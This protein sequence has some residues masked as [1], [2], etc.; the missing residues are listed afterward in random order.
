MLWIAQNIF[1]VASAMLRTIDYIEAYSLTRLRIAA[2]AWMALVAFGLAA[3]CW[4]LLRDRSAAWLIN[5]NLAAAGL[6]LT[7]ASFIDLGAIAAQ[8]NVR[9]AREVGGQGAA[10]DLCYLSELEAS[11]LLPLIALEQRPGLQPAFR[12]RVQ[13]VRSRV[14]DALEDSQPQG[15]TL[16]GQRQLEQVRRALTQ[17]KP[18][19]LQ[20]GAR[21]CDGALLPPPPAIAAPPPPPLSTTS[22]DPKAVRALTG[23]IGK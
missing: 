4:R 16:L 6:A 9:H 1:L 21:A 3:I 20:P 12:E 18:P 7:A 8:W 13:A 22:V 11:A 2:L 10:L 15:W 19:V 14:Y 23:E 17:Q 5:V